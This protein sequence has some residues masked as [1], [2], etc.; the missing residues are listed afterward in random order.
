[1]KKN[2]IPW[3]LLP[4]LLLCS[5]LFLPSATQSFAKEP[6]S[7]AAQPFLYPVS[8]ILSVTP[9]EPTV[10][11]PD[12]K[13][14]TQAIEASDLSIEMGASPFFIKAKA[15]GG[16]TLSFCSKNTEVAKVNKST[17]RVTLVGAGT[18]KIIIQ[19]PATEEY[20]KASKT[21]QLTVKKGNAKLKAAKASYTKPY[22]S[23]AFSLRAS[24]RCPIKYKSSNPKVAKVSSKGKV[25]VLK[26]GEAAI[27]ITAGSKDYKTARKKVVVKV[28]P[29]AAEIVSAKS[30]S[31][32]QLTVLWKRQREADG[33]VLEY[34][35]DS[36]FKQYVEKKFIS[37]NK[38]VSAT[39]ENLQ[40]GKKYFV[41]V[42]AYKT[43]NR[44]K[45]YGK[46]SKVRSKRIK[47]PVATVQPQTTAQ[48]GKRTL[49]NLLLTAK[50]PLGH[51]MYVWGGGWNEEDTGAGVE[52]VTIGE[53][54]RWR[55]FYEMQDSSYHYQNTRYQIHDGLDCSGYVGFVVYNVLESVNGNPGYVEK[56]GGMA[57][58]F[59]AR[60]FGSYT[61][62][63]SVTD[64]KPGD[65]MSMK[66][67]VWISL[68]MCRD[69]S[70]VLLHASPP[71]VLLCGTSLPDGSRSQAVGLAE[72][73]MGTYYPDWYQKFPDC[74]RGNSYL[75]N[76]SQMRWSPQVLSDEEG[77][78][79]LGAEEVLKRIFMV[80]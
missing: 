28:V 11:P 17:G 69:G 14:K 35:T 67:H 60:G 76:S 24:A 75:E 41:R 80:P 40:E 4:V 43:M 51:T 6:D 56:A 45:A 12:Q 25:T 62:F 77:I 74:T 65:I 78:R 63:H 71:G 48:P 13:K 57:Q 1:M 3:I 5:S 49:L 18:A 15:D 10:L 44:K 68:G 34:T 29:K 59:S 61:P 31:P 64:W 27:T 66:G 33:Y 32:G 39:L 8:A 16:G 79:D 37:K 53:S 30:S 36:R 50:I 58:S 9:S 21:I 54:P 20:E 70:V 38:T 46:A 73:Y 72:A 22:Q 19:A 7:Q 2:K 55:A 23:K 47:K 26:C 42:K 52:A